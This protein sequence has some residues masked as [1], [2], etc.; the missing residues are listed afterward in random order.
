MLEFTSTSRPS[1]SPSI[2]DLHVTRRFWA[3]LLALTLLWSGTPASGVAAGIPHGSAAHQALPSAV[4][5]QAAL[6]D[7]AV[8]GRAPRTGY[9]RDLFGRGWV[10]V[11]RNGCDTRNDILRRDLRARTM[12]GTCVVVSGRLQD[13]YSARSVFFVRGGA[14]EVDI[15]HVVALS[16]AW[17][18]G[19]QQWSAAKRVA[20]ANDP[21]NLLAADASLNRAKGDSDAASWL[22]P[23]RASWCSYVARQ[24]AVK[25]KYELWVTAAEKSAMERVL[26][27]CPGQR[28]PAPGPQPTEASNLGPIATVTP[29]PASTG[30]RPLDPRFTSCSAAKAAG[31]TRTYVRGVDPEYVWY[32]DADGDGRVCE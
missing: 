7:L 13:P 11:D 26:S 25:R 32:R 28:L 18:K 12:Q 3:P 6:G 9:D 5:A 29:S 16:D 15:D 21:L 24:I 31:I 17:Q 30:T 22:P 14:S 2:C 1:T 19:A 10:D 27:G 4:Q 8:K 20:F 23:R